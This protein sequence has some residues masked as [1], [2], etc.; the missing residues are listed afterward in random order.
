MG[1]VRGGGRV[2]TDGPVDAVAMDEC[3]GR[4]KADDKSGH[5][6]LGAAEGGGDGYCLGGES[7][8]QRNTDGGQEE[9][10]VYVAGVR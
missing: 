2:Q 8:H 6:V 9:F 3:R 1:P 4:V 5:D 7:N 10:V